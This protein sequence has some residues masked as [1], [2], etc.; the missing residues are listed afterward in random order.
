M[1]NSQ[2]RRRMKVFNPFSPVLLLFQEKQ[3][4][5]PVTMVQIL[6][7]TSSLRVIL[8]KVHD[9]RIFVLILRVILFLKSSNHIFF[10]LFGNE[11]H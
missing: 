10:H 5:H 4:S 7:P 9:M 8:D 3:L 1:Q 11:V 2:N 6:L